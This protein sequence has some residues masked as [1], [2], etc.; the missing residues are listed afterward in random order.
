MT[1]TL[2]KRLTRTALSAFLSPHAHAFEGC[3]MRRNA[4][5]DPAEMAAALRFLA[6]RAHEA[7]KALETHQLRP[8]NAEV[9]E[10][11]VA[12]RQL[13]DD[14]RTQSLHHLVPYVS[15]LRHQVQTRLS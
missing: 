3:T 9:I 1:Q 11:M 2:N 15:A 14:F 10:L 13:E 7:V 5:R 12:I 6:T 4:H 8:A